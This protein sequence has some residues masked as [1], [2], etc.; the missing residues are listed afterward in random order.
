LT[1]TWHASYV[2]GTIAAPQKATTPT[3]GKFTR[4]LIFKSLHVC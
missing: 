1:E 3:A 2:A 4:N